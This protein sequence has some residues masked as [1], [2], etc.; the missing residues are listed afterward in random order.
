MKV[1]YHHFFVDYLTTLSNEY[2]H[3]FLTLI[4]YFQLVIILALNVLGIN[5]L[6]GS[7][8][9]C[10]SSQCVVNGELWLCAIKLIEKEMSN[11]ILNQF[12]SFEGMII[13][14]F[15]CFQGLL[16]HYKVK[17][18]IFYLCYFSSLSC[19]LEYYTFF[20]LSLHMNFV[21]FLLSFDSSIKEIFLYYN[22]QK[23][24]LHERMV[25]LHQCFTNVSFSSKAS[26]FNH[27][28][29]FPTIGRVRQLNSSFVI[30]I[31]EVYKLSTSS[32][33]TTIGQ[34]VQK[35]HT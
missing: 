12:L 24:N 13:S 26:A 18:D 31:K 35:N 20:F 21:K 15:V 30:V 4:Q 14:F 23:D 8:L 10:T 25:K 19:S 29:I 7:S 9:T 27:L 1:Y 5:V 3:F 2:F 28:T 22:C 16:A 32:K 17:V 11:E 6:L 33:T 34:H